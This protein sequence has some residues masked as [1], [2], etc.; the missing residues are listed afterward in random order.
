MSDILSTAARGR[1][2]LVGV[3]LERRQISDFGGL[4]Q[5]SYGCRLAP[6]IAPSSVGGDEAL[7]LLEPVLDD[8]DLVVRSNLLEH[9]EALAVLGDIV[10]VWAST[11]LYVNRLF[12]PIRIPK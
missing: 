10:A 5:S 9:Q 11:S 7:Q 4:C 12:Y 1:I 2:Q 3:H 6:D 8:H